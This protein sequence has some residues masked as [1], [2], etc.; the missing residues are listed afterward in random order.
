[1]YFKSVQ[2]IGAIDPIV[3]KKSQL[4]FGTGKTIW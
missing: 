1:M 4:T 2:K 3:L